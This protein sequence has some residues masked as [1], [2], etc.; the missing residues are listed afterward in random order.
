MNTWIVLR[1]GNK[2]ENDLMQYD[3]KR[4]KNMDSSGSSGF[5]YEKD[6]RFIH[7]MKSRLDRVIEER[8]AGRLVDAKVVY[9]NIKEQH[10]W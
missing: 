1:G 3:K 2:M 9:A 7:F 8:E 5:D 10:G 6:P 4:E